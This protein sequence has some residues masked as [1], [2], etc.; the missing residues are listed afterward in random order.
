MIDDFIKKGLPV[1]VIYDIGAN[2][3][4]WSKLNKTGILEN[5]EFILFEANKQHYDS[6]CGTGFKFFN[7]VLSSP[8]KKSVTFFHRNSAG[9]GDSYYKE[10]SVLYQNDIGETHECRT[11]DSIIEEHNLPL[12]DFIKIDTQG[13]ELDI[14]SGAKTAIQNASFILTECPIIE[15]NEGAPNIH[16]Y[17]TF[18]KENNFVP[19][20]LVEG[21]M[22]D[23]ILVQ[24]DIVFIKREVKE[25]YLG[26]TTFIKI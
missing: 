14:L 6:L 12:P 18:M 24:I 19:V 20:Y 16:E 7:T 11:L 21:H 4:S 5:T 8:E 25:R 26:A 13:S 17:L 22:M 1:N 15:Y 10:K 23:N 9:T 2:N 3:G